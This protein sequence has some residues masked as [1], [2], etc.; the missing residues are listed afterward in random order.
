MESF[1]YHDP[2]WQGVVQACLGCCSGT[3][4]S[5]VVSRT[6]LLN[7]HEFSD[8]SAN[9]PSYVAASFFFQISNC[10]ATDSRPPEPKLCRAATAFLAPSTCETSPPMCG[11]ACC[12]SSNVRSASR[13]FFSSQ[14]A[15]SFPTVSGDVRIGT[16][17]LMRYSISVVASR[18][19]SSMQPPT[20]LRF[21][22]PAP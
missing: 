8:A 5:S 1:D 18:K 20:V 14:R 6:T 21:H 10:S 12:N 11:H 2:R 13:Q 9:H 22:H 15:T 16:P 4:E 3:R 7:S 19:P 17:R